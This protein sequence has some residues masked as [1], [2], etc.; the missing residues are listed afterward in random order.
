MFL[1]TLH[2]QQVMHE[3]FT[4]TPFFP[5]IIIL[6]KTVLGFGCFAALWLFRFYILVLVHYCYGSPAMKRC[7]AVMINLQFS[8]ISLVGRV[9]RD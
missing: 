7:Y 2:I 5:I 3:K 6:F 9:S 4:I 8:A 1:E